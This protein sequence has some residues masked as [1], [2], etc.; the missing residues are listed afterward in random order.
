MT[1][2]PIQWPIRKGLG[3]HSCILCGDLIRALRTESDIAVSHHWGVSI[4]TVNRWRQAL[5]AARILEVSP[6][7]SAV[8][9]PRS[10]EF[11]KAISERAK[12]M[13]EHPEQHG[14]P[15]CHRWTDEEIALLGTA[16]DPIIAKRLGIPRHNVESKRRRLGIPGILNRW[17]DEEIALLGTD[18]DAVIARRL[19][20][21]AV[22]VR[23]KRE[24]LGIPPMMTRWTNG[25]IVLLGTDTDQA[26]AEKL[27]KSRM[28]VKSKRLALG[29]PAFTRAGSGNRQGLHGD[30]ESSADP[31]DIHE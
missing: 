28:G 23:D 15:P 22:G 16:P 11:K 24:K 14:L 31:E 19:G 17:T 26:I 12:R 8:R 30:R 2:A 4:T 20:R 9:R 7:P 5:E 3:R 21:P 1:N 25:E 13:W 27:G 6:R 29:I 18:S 10:A